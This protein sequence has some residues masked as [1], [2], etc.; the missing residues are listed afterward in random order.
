MVY[1]G[2]GKTSFKPGDEITITLVPTKNGQP[3]GRINQVVLPN[4][5][6]LEAEGTDSA[7]P[8]GASKPENYPKQ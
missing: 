6:T 7:V 4:G 2:W 3:F 1:K 8:S 5:R